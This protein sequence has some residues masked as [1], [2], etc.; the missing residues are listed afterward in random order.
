MGGVLGKQERCF[1][2]DRQRGCR[3]AMLVQFTQR[4]RL[5]RQQSSETLQ[6]NRREEEEE[7]ATGRGRGSEGADR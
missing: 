4:G 6:I 3:E 5:R 7:E 1:G 2:R